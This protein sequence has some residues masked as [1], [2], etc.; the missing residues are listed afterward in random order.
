MYASLPN[1]IIG[2]HGCDKSVAGDVI[3]GNTTLIA[4]QNDYDWLGHGIYFWENNPNRA[5]E[6]AQMLKD[7]PGRTKG[8]VNKPAVVGAI[9]DLGYS[10]PKSCFFMNEFFICADLITPIYSSD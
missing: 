9:I 5:F 8:M 10:S 6:Y 1:F 2:F 7:N 3:N 4:S